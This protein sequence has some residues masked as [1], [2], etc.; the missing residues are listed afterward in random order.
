MVGGMRA[1]RV[2]H[3]GAILIPSWVRYDDIVRL[4]AII[5]HEQRGYGIIAFKN[6]VTFTLIDG[7]HLTSMEYIKER[8]MELIAAPVLYTHMSTCFVRQYTFQ[9]R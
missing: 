9:M 1:S 2:Y 7:I 5:L 3:L 6:H 4:G 8:Y